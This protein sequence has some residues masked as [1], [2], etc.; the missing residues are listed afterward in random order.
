VDDL[1]APLGRNQTSER[2][3]AAAIGMSLGVVTFAA[4]AMLVD[5]PRPSSPRRNR[6]ELDGKGG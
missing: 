2:R 1:T 3:F 5:D 6:A 4:W